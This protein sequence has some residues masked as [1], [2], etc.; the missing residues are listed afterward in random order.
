MTQP[1]ADNPPVSSP[2]TD[3]AKVSRCCCRKGGQGCDKGGCRCCKAV[4]GGLVV[5]L[6]LGLGAELYARFY[7]GLGDPPLVMADDKIEYLFQPNQSG[8]RFGNRYQYNAYSMRSDDFPK[9]KSDPKELRVM[10]LGDSVVNGGNLTD[11]KDVATQV[12]QG[13]LREKLGRPVVVGHVSAGSWGPA[14]MAAY[15]EKYGL[16]DADMVVLVLSS[17]DL[18]DVPTFEPLVGVN[19]SFP[20]RKPWL[21]LEEAIFRYLPGRLPGWLVSKKNEGDPINE[22]QTPA[23]RQIS[24]EAIEKLASIAAAADVPVMVALHLSRTEQAQGLDPAGVEL[25]EVLRERHL[26]MM[27]L[28]KAFTQAMAQGQVL[29]RDDIHPSAAGNRVIGQAL[30]QEVA[31]RVQ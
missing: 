27:E 19:A 6:L 14:N 23:N 28:S 11:Q 15:V 22:S 31:R 2:S 4:M 17:H 25:R 21:A 13:L 29:Y 20:N 9:T 26:P 1:T 24:I 30:A 18:Y 12:M 3:P 8:Y 10:V 16:M 7:L 5:L